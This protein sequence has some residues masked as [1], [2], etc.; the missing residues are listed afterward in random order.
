MRYNRRMARKIVVC[1]GK[2]GVGKTTVAANL[3]AKISQNG[4]RVCI[5][6]ADF[7]LNNLDVAVGA[8][9]IVVYDVADCVEGRCR[10]KQALA[11][12][13]SAKNAYILP[14]LRPLSSHINAQKAVKELIEGL[15]LSFDYILIDCP[16]GTSEG[17][18]IAVSAA[19][20]AL[21]VTTPLL[22]SLRDADKTLSILRGRGVK[23]IGLVVNRTRGDLVASG[24]SLSPED[25]EQ[26]LKCPLVGII[27]E[28]DNVFLRNAGQIPNESPSAK[29]FKILAQNILS[30]KNKRYDYLS[31]YVGFWGSLR[32]IIK[33]R[34]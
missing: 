14:S 23:S 16:A 12:F 28:D 19:E 2:G 8:E 6:D 1:S 32:R 33:K 26:T 29:A 22:S 24:D 3:G 11:P 7:G 18:S 13:P 21:V 17:F 9:N 25:I 15:S 30:G 4:K 31:P 34:L 20:E 5:V 10:A 27:P